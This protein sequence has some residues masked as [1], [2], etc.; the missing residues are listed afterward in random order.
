MKKN[1]KPINRYYRIVKDPLPTLNKS[2][3][4]NSP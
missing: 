1:E 3:T 4:I 2:L